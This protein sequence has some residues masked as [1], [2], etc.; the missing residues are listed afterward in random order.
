MSPSRVLIIGGSGFIGP[1]LI[2]ALLTHGTSEIAILNRGRRFLPGVVA[3]AADRNAELEMACAARSVGDLDVV[4]DLSCFNRRQAAVAW[5]CFG[6]KARRWICLSSAAVYRPV[7]TGSPDELTPTGGG[8]LWGEY[9]RGKAEAE[10]HLVATAPT[11]SVAC[12]RAPYVYGPGNTADRETFVWSRLLRGRT[13]FVP[14]DGTTMVDFIH[15]DDLVAAILACIDAPRLR[16]AHYN[17]STEEHLTLRKLV[18]VLAVACGCSE[19]CLP[20]GNSAPG[21]DAL[22]YFPFRDVPCHLA[23]SMLTEELAWRPQ[24]SSST[25]FARTFRSYSSWFLKTRPILTRVEDTLSAKLV[26]GVDQ[27]LLARPVR[28]PA[29]NAP[30]GSDGP[31]SASG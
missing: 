27:P 2:E 8:E 23:G 21:I 24:L 29:E 13:I 17:V 10:D 11:G 3:L 16:S 26:N 28:I 18:N 6:A 7:A 15:V 14:G 22:T 25:G 30:V 5:S 1:R 20:V 4:V 12:L 31:P 9:G 19:S